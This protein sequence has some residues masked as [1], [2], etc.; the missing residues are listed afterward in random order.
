MSERD[1]QLTYPLSE[2]S[3]K[4]TKSKAFLQQIIKAMNSF[5]NDGLNFSDTLGMMC[6][7]NLQASK[8]VAKAIIRELFNNNLLSETIKGLKSVR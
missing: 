7:D 5:D 3:L 8:K 2:D 6:I 4:I 1:L